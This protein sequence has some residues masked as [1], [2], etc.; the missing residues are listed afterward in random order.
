MSPEQ[1]ARPSYYIT[2]P[3]YYTSGQP[4][5]GHSYT[6]VAADTMARLRRM[7]GY[8]VMF[9]TGTDEHGRKVQ[10]QAEAAGV[11]PQAFVDALVDDY[12]ALWKLMGITY[13]RFIR[14]TDPEHQRSVQWVFSELERR[15]DIYL[16]E[17]EGWYCVPCESFWTESQLDEEGHCPDCGRAVERTREESYFFRLSKYTDRII[18]LY[19]EHT[20]FIQPASRANEMLNNFLL[21]GLEDL[22]VSRTSFSW[23]VPVPGNPRHVIYVWIDALFNYLTA[24]G[25]PHAEGEP[26]LRY[27]PAD[28]QLV[29]KEI[30]RFHSI[31]WPAMLMALDLPLPRQ[32][33]GHG[34]LLFREG[35]MSKSMGN[36]IDPIVLCERY[37]VD[38]LRYFLLR[39]MPFGSDGN[40]SNEAL[41]LRINADLANDLGNLLS[42]TTAMIDRYFDGVLPEAREAGA[43]DDEL[44]ELAA[45]VPP[46]VE[47]ALDE[48]QFSQAL[49]EI[50]RLV[51]RSN[52]YIDET[53]PWLLAR[54][55]AQRPRLAMVLQQLA[56]ALRQ[57][58]VMIAPFMP[59]SSAAILAALAVADD[60]E[61]T[62]WASAHVTGLCRPAAAI[63]PAAP[64]FPRLD[65]DEEIAYMKRQLSPAGDGAAE[66]QPAAE[67]PQREAKPDIAFD[68]FTKLELR[69]AVVTACERVKGADRLLCSQLDLGG[70]ETRQV[71]SGIAETYAPEEVVG[72]RVVLVANLAPRRIRGL[73]S[74][75]ML[76]CAEDEAGGFRLI[77]APEGVPA[78]SE[79][80]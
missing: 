14:T 42:R 75:G 8:D 16:S 35:K 24:L 74:Q 30:V 69:V 57:V 18:A 65:R 32:I 62:S 63:R 47:A 45:A 12:R 71:L 60:P 3:I 41:V 55:E 25:Y 26:W 72:R 70:G 31:I 66:A 77:E 61:Q 51:G 29:G 34:W 58:G 7:Q 27:W 39:E 21:P 28:V 64:R 37:G 80:S 4:H 59:D 13:D 56:S 23:G 68:D 43:H 33:Y 67:A 52:K 49:A 38:A 17:Y 79:V 20:E 54:D 15:G 6:T 9:L 53:E 19:R 78:G 73:D 50:W 36:V 22:A 10:D 46:A 48:L 40:F 44:L 5:I 11:S 2:T 1:T 76:L